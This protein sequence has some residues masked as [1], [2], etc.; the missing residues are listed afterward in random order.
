MEQEKEAED[1][2]KEEDKKLD[3]CEC[4]KQE[5]LTGWQRARADFLNYKKEEMERMSELLKYGQEELILKF[6]LI[7]DN[8]ERACQSF[9]QQG[10]DEQ[11]QQ[12]AQ[13]FFQV[14]KQMQ[15]FLK[16]HGVDEIEVKIGDCFD[17][18]FQEIVE[19][20]EKQGGNSKIIEIMGKG[21]KINGR[22]LR[23]AKVKVAK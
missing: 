11:I 2:K 5:Y 20:I 16:A 4:L 15:D 3:E 6:L 18:N 9:P 22:L 8:I 7:L 21:Y 1:K 23:P 12:I 13:G 17:P 14:K 19:E 10:L